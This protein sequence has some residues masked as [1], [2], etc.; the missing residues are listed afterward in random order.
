MSIQLQA[1]KD[2][3]LFL[4]GQGYKVTVDDEENIFAELN[5]IEYHCEYFPQGFIDSDDPAYIEVEIL[6][7]QKPLSDMSE[8]FNRYKDNI[9]TRFYLSES[10]QAWASK[11]RNMQAH[12]IEKVQM[13]NR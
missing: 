6:T 12:F 7:G 3:T 2:F 11:L 9:I 13:S 8:I 5:G 1:V 10:E 4:L